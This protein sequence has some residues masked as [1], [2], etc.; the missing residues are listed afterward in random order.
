MSKASVNTNN[1]ISGK[2]DIVHL[3]DREHVLIRPNMYIGETTN[4]PET[5]YIYD[6]EN[7][8]IKE[9]EINY[10]AG[11]F[12]IFDEILDNAV[13]ETEKDKT[14]NIIKVNIKDNIISIYNNGL[15]IE[16]EKDEKENIYIPQLLFGYLRT[17]TNYDDTQERN[18][19][20]M[21]GIG[22]K[23]TNIFSKYFKIDIVS[24]HKHYSQTFKD[25]MS[26]VDKPKIT[27]IKSTLS[28]VKIEFLPDYERF[29]LSE[30][31]QDMQQLFKKRVYDVAFYLMGK[32]KVYFNEE[33]INIKSFDDYLNLYFKDIENKNIIK[34]Q[35]KKWKTALIYNPNCGFKNIS[36]VNGLTVNKGGNHIKHIIN[37]V[38]NSET[39]VIAN[40]NK[41][42]K[43]LKIRPSYIKDNITLVV[44]CIIDKP[45]FNSQS[46]EE[47]TNNITK[48]NGVQL[49][50]EFINN[51]MK[52]DLIDD[53]IKTATFK[54]SQQ[55]AKTDGKR[56]RRE[57]IE[58]YNPAGWAGGPKSSECLLIITEGDSA[59]T[60]GLWGIKQYEQQFG[61][62]FNKFGIFPIRGKMLNVLNASNQQII[63]NN[64]ITNIKK[65]IGLEQGKV[66]N[67]ETAKKLNYGG[68]LI[69]TDQDLDGFHISGLIINFIHTFWRELLQVDGFIKTL[70][71]PILKAFKKGAKKE[72]PIIFYHQSDYNKWIKET[73]KPEQYEIKY[74]KGLGTSTR[75]EAMESFED[76]EDKVLV[77]K[78]E[79]QTLEKPENSLISN[80]NTS[81]PASPSQAAN[82]NKK[83]ITDKK[84]IENPTISDN[85][86]DLAFN[87][88]RVEDRKEWLLNYNPDAVYESRDGNIPYSKYFNNNFIHFSNYDN[89]R[90]IPSICDGLKPSQRKI[91]YTVVKKNIKKA[92]NIKVS[93][94]ANK[95]SEMTCYLH[96]ETSL[97]EAIVNMAQQ[98]VGTN[99]INLL[100]PLGNFG[101]R[102]QG[103]KDSA[104]TRY[105][106]T[107][108]NTL[109]DKIYRKE[110]QV[111]LKNKIEENEIIEPYNYYSII[112]MPLINGAIGIGTGY[113]TRIPLFNPVD[114]ID[115]LISLI[116]KQETSINLKPWYYGFNGYIKKIK[117]RGQ[118]NFISI[119]KCKI[120]NATRNGKIHISELPVG[121]WIEDYVN[122]IKKKIIANK[123]EEIKDKEDII[124]KDI[125]NKSS[126][127]D[128]NITLTVNSTFIQD[129]QRNIYEDPQSFINIDGQ[130]ISIILLQKLKLITPLNISNMY[131]YDFNNKI[132]KYEKPEDI[133]IDFFNNRYSLYEERKKI[134]IKILEN[135]MN[136]LKWRIK[137]IDD[138]INKIIII[139]RRK[140]EEIIK[141]LEDL[142][143]PKLNNNYNAEEKDKN[144][145]YII[146]IKLFDLTE[147]KLQELN[148]KFN[149]KK[150]ELENYKQTEAYEIWKKELMELKE[151]YIIEYPPIINNIIFKQTKTTRRKRQPKN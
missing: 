134:Y 129:C 68:I 63:K 74:Y 141:Q 121:V 83:K 97:S 14:C 127:D 44:S 124:F 4:V 47:L 77:Y 96:G 149:I 80:S 100:Y 11:L 28:Y 76:F 71:T 9:K 136:L 8:I 41:K 91:L 147:D 75:E 48:A 107:Y 54:E 122:D 59:K 2:R 39:G 142:K 12:K 16:I 108:G 118:T 151:S 109:L 112:P 145:N 84:E 73:E 150:D 49:P 6:E 56:G 106:F 123:S 1:N 139:E 146:D 51:I 53:V 23:G 58:K 131:L 26:V 67:N 82:K 90:S 31:S 52:S 27:P 105:I 37:Q 32:V 3:S 114:V 29:G 120:N 21:N 93:Q 117:H 36:I 86:I 64:E 103:G 128:V 144:Y 62:G 148:Q 46:K 79:T 125:E 7:K 110:D 88:E 126:P 135:E 116:D 20:G 89:I 104:A 18:V 40:I 98:F 61:N 102:N 65:I 111:I 101:T 133:L 78:W 70:Q 25:N 57:I 119:G 132:K 143:Y 115:N 94:L 34:F 81:S 19:S 5:L 99:N 42:Y 24:N 35:N 92:N 72:K 60:F 87:G 55:L 17:S 140:K 95:V 33:L 66:Y 138:Y 10:N 38:L 69:L 15:G 113:S 130:D 137:F 13:D 30:L 22:A 43:E 45:K 50:E 85:A